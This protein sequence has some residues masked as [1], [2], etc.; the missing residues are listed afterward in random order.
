MRALILV[1]FALSVLL[2]PVILTAASA[3]TTKSHGIAIHGEPGYPADFTHFKYVNPNAPKGG[4]LRIAS[5]GTFDSFNPYIIK[6]VPGPGFN[7]E[8]LLV[9]S[10][11]EASSEYGLIAETLEWPDDRSWVIFTL[12]SEARWH[13]GKPITVEDVIF[14]LDTIRKDADPYVKNYYGIIDRIEKID[15][16]SVKFYSAEPGNKEFPI[17]AGSLPIFAKHYWETR[18]FSK[19][20]LEP[21]LGSGPYKVTDFEAGRYVVQERVKDYW[22]KDLPVNKGQDN[23]D[24]LRTTYYHDSDVIKLAIKS[25]EIDY[26][27]ERS[28]SAWAQDYDVPAITKGWL[29]K[30]SIPHKRP[31]GIQGYFLNTR[32]DIFKDP[33]VREALGYAYDFEW[34]NNNLSY[35]LLTRSTNFFGNSELSSSGLP[36]GKELEILEQYRGKVTDRL[37]NEP[38]HVPKTD[39]KGWPRDNYHKA[40]SLLAE[41]GWV[42]RDLKLVNEKTGE[43]MSFEML[44][45]S[46]G[47]E[48]TVLPFA[49]SLSKL[50]IEAKIRLVDRSQYYNRIR[51]F[52]YDVVIIKLSASITPGTEQRGF[53]TSKTANVLGSG[54][55]SGISDP[56]IDELVESVVN[57]EDRK[58]LVANVRA[59]DRLLLWGFYVIPQFHTEDDRVLYWDKFSRPK[60]TPWR[61]T[62][63]SYWWFD[64]EKEALLIATMAKN[65][66]SQTTP[67]EVDT[68]E[69]VTTSNEEESFFDPAILDTFL[70]NFDKLGLQPQ[71]VKEFF[72]FQLFIDPKTFFQKNN[73]RPYALGSTLVVLLLLMMRRRRKRGEQD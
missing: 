40:F 17:R 7:P 42:V 43:Q 13:D 6:G 18:D 10:A 45:A 46:K 59:L 16:S 51:D 33:K 5:E 62:S 41:A 54:N 32:R 26:R 23:F 19:S 27:N 71:K 50:G 8:S 68:S 15:E 67:S 29:K 12:R 55:F 49:T 34:T 39:G 61:G 69:V 11:D 44:V 2:P 66:A 36:T 20:T 65:E 73:W 21:P 3:A 63:T 30:E 37:F 72:T 58:E 56:V 24:A 38:F 1:S 48:R 14:S 9:S 57:A 60:I 35:G 22:G 28:S 47:M 4:E 70:E 64:K 53:W 52:D 25:G 31:Q